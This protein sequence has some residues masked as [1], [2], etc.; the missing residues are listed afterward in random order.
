ML[1]EIGRTAVDESTLS[2]AKSEHAHT[3]VAFDLLRETTS[4]LALSAG[5]MREGT[6]CW[7]AH[8]AVLAGHMV[9]LARL[10][11]ALLQDVNERRAEVAWVLAR[12]L[13][14]TGI[15]LRYLLKHRSPELLNRFLYQ[16]LQKDLEL[17]GRIR[18]NIEERGGE[19]PPIE[20]RMLRSIERSLAW[21]AVEREDVPSS[22][23]A[24]WGGGSF[25]GRLK[26]LGMEEAYLG[27]FGFPSSNVHGGWHDL[28]QHSLEFEEGCG[29]VPH[30]DEVEV[31]PQLLHSIIHVV[32]AAA[33]D[34]LEVFPS[35]QISP[36]SQRLDEVAVRAV[37]AD[38][39]HEAWLVEM[40]RSKGPGA[41]TADN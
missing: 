15:N 19:V 12:M 35:G 6:Q 4:L 32:L 34:Y 23:I 20:E 2:A 38:Q 7:S 1:S 41:A 13:Y 30:F 36:V 10:C 33:K 22:R 26:D 3:E 27:L 9:R 29:F 14:E 40:V 24:H 11:R 8:D 17:E 28:V 5:I 37:R 18:T 16:S 25:R 39:L 21:A 31:R